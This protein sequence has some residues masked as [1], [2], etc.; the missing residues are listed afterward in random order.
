[1][2]KL[3][4]YP[5]LALLW[6]YKIAISPLLSAFGVKCR[7]YPSCSSYSVEAIERHG[8]WPGGWMTLAR[9]LRCHPFKRLG[10]THGVDNVPGN[11]Y[12]AAFMGAVAIW[13]MARH[14]YGLKQWSL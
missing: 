13:S 1:M 3:F 10:G 4:A 12:K 2:G 9:L 6:V 5:M 14:E 8:P 11:H 7:H